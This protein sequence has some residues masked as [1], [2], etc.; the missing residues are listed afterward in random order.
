MRALLISA[1]I[2]VA[3]ACACACGEAIVIGD[4]SDARSVSAG[5]PS[6]FGDAGF[7]GALSTA[8]TDP[9][10]TPPL[11]GGRSYVCG[12]HAPPPPGMCDGSRPVQLYNPSTKCPEGHAC[13][14][15][16]CGTAGGA[17]VARSS[18][19]CPSNTYGPATDYAC[20]T[21]GTVCCLP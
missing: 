11:D 19:S 5:G 7:D 8:P 17:C 16:D 6:L 9:I 1:S 21:I 20:H 14:P 18:S 12:I 3:C 4:D 10:H 2:I 15:I 13:A